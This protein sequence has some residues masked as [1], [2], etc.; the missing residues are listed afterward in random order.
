MPMSPKDPLQHIIF[1][2]LPA[3]SEVRVGELDLDTT[4]PLPLE[5]EDA[6]EE[7]DPEDI[8][9]EAI[10]AGTL[11]ILAYR[12][13]HSDAEYFRRFVLAARPNINEELTEA[14]IFKVRNGDL[15]LAE[16]L[17][18]ALMGLFPGNPQ[19]AVN[20]ALAYEERV[21]AALAAEDQEE[22]HRR[23]QEVL[24]AYKRA[25]DI[26][27][28]FPDAHFNLAFFHSEMSEHESC[29]C[30]LELYLKYGSDAEKMD[31]ARALHEQ[32]DAG[33]LGDALFGDAVAAIRD[34]NERQGIEQARRFVQKHPDTWNGWFVLGWGLRRVGEYAEACSSFERALQLG[35]PQ[36]DV[37]NELSICHL[38]IG[39]LQE[40]ERCL[41]IA[42][43]MAPEDTRVISNIGVLHLRRGDTKSALSYFRTVQAIDPEDPVATRY[44]AALGT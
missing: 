38:E 16:E 3:T 4:I 40:C 25:L 14:A 21:R 2:N 9:W 6:I 13:G 35:E 10:I 11:K 22:T 39:N 8:T 44:L 28:L 32:I 20:L 15:D 23:R 43:E 27:P 17:F 19:P 7:I 1:I 31:Q 42:L 34:G 26:D 41:S 29:R 12:P 5:T 37:L 30:H 33:G 18:L 24:T 36:V